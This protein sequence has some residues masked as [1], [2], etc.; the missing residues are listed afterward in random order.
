MT[1]LYVKTYI[2]FNC[3]NLEMKTCRELCIKLPS[4]FFM[5]SMQSRVFQ[6]R[7]PRLFTRD[8]WPETV[9]YSVKESGLNR[10]SS[11]N[12]LNLRLLDFSKKLL[13][14]RVLSETKLLLRNKYYALVIAKICK[15]CK[16]V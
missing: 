3:A 8:S 16:C 12:W 13:P 15:A 9:G 2:A 11:V 1:A 7:D 4:Y 5:F 6:T 10:P 14:L